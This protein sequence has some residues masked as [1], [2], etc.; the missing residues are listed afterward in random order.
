[1]QILPGGS[2]Q[3]CCKGEAVVMIEFRLS[4]PD[5]AAGL[6]RCVAAVAQ[7]RRHLAVVCGF[8]EDQTR[9][10]MQN[11]LESGG[12]QVL[13]LDENAVVGWSDIMP[14]QY[15][16]MR[17]VGRLGMGLLPSH[18]GQGLGKRLLRETLERAFS[19]RLV[20]IELD[21]FASNL[22]AVHL[23]SQAGFVTEGRKRRARI[24]D[25]REENIIL[26][27]LLREEWLR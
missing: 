21:V 9:A 12:I 22:A 7:E 17:H 23:Y 18:R 1:M 2:R 25:G 19:D 3:I 20:R 27:G 6:S 5:D 10:Y 14:L 26:M 11:L 13:V 8:T 24:L 4:N 15:E 16:G